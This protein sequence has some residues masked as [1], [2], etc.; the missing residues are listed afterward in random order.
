MPSLLP[1]HRP[2]NVFISNPVINYKIVRDIL[3][4]PRLTNVDRIFYN[5]AKWISTLKLS[6]DAIPHSHMMKSPISIFVSFLCYYYCV[7]LD[8]V[9]EEHP[10]S[11]I[12]LPPFLQRKQRRTASVAAASSHPLP[13]TDH[14]RAG[15]SSCGWIRFAWDVLWRL[16][17]YHLLDQWRP[18]NSTN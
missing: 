9:S 16:P 11:P 10:P 1:N 4:A 6:L 18:T 8:F 2:W 12:T 3:F 13:P 17:S 7:T 15:A 5:S 14:R